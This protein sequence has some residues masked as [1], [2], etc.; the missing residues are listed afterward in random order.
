MEKKK[1]RE[2]KL[3]RE[4]EKLKELVSMILPTFGFILLSVLL[5]G[6]KRNVLYFM[7]YDCSGYV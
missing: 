5:T 6:I 1:E 3:Q 7:L 4:F 2:A